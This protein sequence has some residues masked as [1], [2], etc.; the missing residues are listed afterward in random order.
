MRIEDVNVERLSP[1][2]TDRLLEQ[3]VQSP[4]R[5]YRSLVTDPGARGRQLAPPG[6]GKRVTPTQPGR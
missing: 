6:P 1:L 2:G 4:P 5:T 3:A